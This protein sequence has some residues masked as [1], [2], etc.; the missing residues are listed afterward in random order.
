MGGVNGI[1]LQED[2]V[3]LRID[4]EDYSVL[5]EYDDPRTR[6]TSCYRSRWFPKE[7][8]IQGRQYDET[9]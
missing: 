4:E 5:K 8:A 6:T 2:F 1:F 9:L 3:F 7:E